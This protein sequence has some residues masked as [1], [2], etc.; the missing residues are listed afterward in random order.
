M[1]RS[2][3]T[4]PMPPRGPAVKVT[5]RAVMSVPGRAPLVA[6]FAESGFSGSARSTA[7]RMDA[8]AFRSASPVRDSTLRRFRLPVVSKTRMLLSAVVVSVPRPSAGAVSPCSRL[9]LTSIS[10]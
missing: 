2:L 9:M 4:E 1:S 5:L 6:V 3:P 10:R 8:S 7:S